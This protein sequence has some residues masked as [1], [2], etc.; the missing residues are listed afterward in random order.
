MTMKKR[1]ILFA[2]AAVFLVALLGAA[3]CFGQIKHMTQLQASQYVAEKWQ[4][5][6]N[7]AFCQYSCFFPNSSGYDHNGVWKSRNSAAEYLLANSYSFEQLTNLF[8][9]AWSGKISLTVSSER[10]RNVHVN[11]TAVGGEFF[12]FHPL[13]LL[14][15][16]FLSEG[17]YFANRILISTDLAW[18]LFGGT[19]LEGQLVFVNDMPFSI[20]G[21]FEPQSDTASLKA[22]PEGY[23][24]YVLYSAFADRE[25][26][27][28][29]PPITCYELVMPEPVK[30]FTR[31]FIQKEF[32][33]GNVETLQNTGRF[34]NSALYTAARHRE[35]AAIRTGIAELPPWENAARYTAAKC[36]SLLQ[37]AI[38]LLVLPAAG[39][40]ALAVAAAAKGYA[41]VRDDLLPA[42]GEHIGRGVEN[43]YSRRRK[44]N[45]NR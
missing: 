31:T 32:T 35:D 45:N 22:Q 2:A 42:A 43:I 33:Q 14:S 8:V 41:K 16:S 10:S 44:K 13:R 19:D 26:Q 18:Q 40:T 30:G 5:T 38:W 37:T 15:G 21:V 39:I 7:T 4:G 24:A 17:D 29:N 23:E 11:A 1:R 34:A 36:S 25:D 9:D 20:A 28:E 6:G 12:L 3:I 27:K